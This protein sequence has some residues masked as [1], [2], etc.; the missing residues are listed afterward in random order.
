MPVTPK[1][2]LFILLA[3]LAGSAIPAAV[4]AAEEGRGACLRKAEQRAAVA[5]HRA[6]PLARAIRSLHMRGRRAEVVRAEL[7]DRG[8][9]LVYVLTLL[10]RSG[11][12]TRATIDAGNGEP[13]G[14]H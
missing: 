10:P 6:V 8:G 12:V 14:L 7:C 2:I 11:K 1:L 4:R 13:L 9:R 5:T 3:L